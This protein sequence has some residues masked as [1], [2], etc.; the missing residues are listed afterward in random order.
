MTWLGFCDEVEETGAREHLK[1]LYEI[2]TK[3]SRGEEL[4][5]KEKQEWTISC[6]GL[7]CSRGFVNEEGQHPDMVCPLTEEECSNLKRGR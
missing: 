2:K 4:T 1:A 7:K 6:Y 5:T 3:L